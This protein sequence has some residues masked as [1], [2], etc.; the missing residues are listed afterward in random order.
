MH[1]SWRN[2]ILAAVYSKSIISATLFFL[3]K[4]NGTLNFLFLCRCS[5]LATV[6]LAVKHGSFKLISAAV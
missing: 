2:S 3:S 4:I 5:M 6:V 1:V